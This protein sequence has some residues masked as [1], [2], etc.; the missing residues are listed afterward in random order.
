MHI[1]SE[2]TLKNHPLCPPLLVLSLPPLSSS[3]SSSLPP[4]YSILVY[5]VCTY[6]Q[7][8]PLRTIPRALLSLSSLPP[9]LV[10][11]ALPS[12]RVLSSSSLP[13]LLVLLVLSSP[14]V[15]FLLASWC[16]LLLLLRGLGNVN[17]QRAQQHCIVKCKALGVKC[18]AQYHSLTLQ[19]IGCRE[20]VKCKAQQPR[21]CKAQLG[22]L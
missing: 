10:L 21:Y 4:F 12:P 7:N 16:K 5:S 3:S 8:W 19:S 20:S 15:L 17:D 18:K 1:H 22:V 13:P 14:L 9:L 6:I 11:L 2:L